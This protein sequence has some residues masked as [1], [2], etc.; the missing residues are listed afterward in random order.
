MS[1][2][3]GIV[4]FSGELIHAA[5][6]EPAAQRLAAPGLGEAAHWIEGSA[7]LLVRQRFITHEDLAERQP[8]VG[9]AGRLVLVY[10]GRLDN[11]DEVASLLGIS[12]KGDVV[13]DGRLLLAALERWGEAALPRLIGDFALALWDAQKRRLL[14]ARDQLGSRTL[15]YHQGAGFVAFATTYRALL[16]L[17]GVPKKVDE[18]GIADFLILNVQHPVETFYEGVRRVP[19]ASIALFDGKGLQLTRYWNPEPKRMLRL[20]SDEEY[21]EAARE[22]LERAVSCRLRAKDGIASTMSGGLDSSAVASTAARLLVPKRFL[23]VTS[24]PP[25]GM[26]LPLPKPAW[27]N[28]ERPYVAAI[29]A[30]HP[31]KDSVLASSVD[32][33]WIETDPAAFFE[34]GGLPARNVS[35]IGWLLPGYERLTE[36]GISALLSGEGGNPAWSYDGLRGLCGL[37]KSGNWLRLARELYLTGRR[38]PYGQDWMALLRGEVLRPLEPLLL[39]KWRRRLKTGAA[40]LWSG[41][42]GI[43]PDFARDIGLSERSRR[44]GHDARMVGPADGLS[45]RL[46]MLKRMEHGHDIFTAL[47]A[48]TGIE[49]RSP[50]LDIR[51]LEFCLSIPGEQFLKDGNFRRLPRLA[52]AGRLP[53]PVLEN[54]L[55]GSQN[56][57][58]L[59]RIEATRST[60]LAEIEELTQVP[61]AVRALD[62]PRLS[63]IVRDWPDGIEVTLLLPRALHVG[64]FLRWAEAG[65]L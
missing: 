62:L 30:L 22:L 63:R 34:A 53:P 48:L 26:K 64:R 39:A 46:T 29:A 27:Y 35:N 55:L 43:H 8:W 2:I 54:N 14:L 20:S 7:G 36:A 33:H 42:S 12:L 3:A 5:D 51:L 25:E 11:R 56:P 9:G 59:Q 45:M 23:T 13:P 65:K 47:R 19:G 28:D 21:V 37:L 41:Y 6:L 60:M 50:L 57:E 44:A 49:T 17:P 40:D 32:P 1:V 58:I 61:L 10:D 31:N 18:L 4:R 38:R 52:M 24:V 16:A 15:Y